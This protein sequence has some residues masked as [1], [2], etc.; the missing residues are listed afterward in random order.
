[1]P[2]FH[3]AVHFEKQDF[4][5]NNIRLFEIHGGRGYAGINNGSRH[6]GCVQKNVIY[7][8]NAT[9]TV[10]EINNRDIDCKLYERY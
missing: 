6:G 2:T 8:I 10:H 3:H 1:M 5:R 9:K 4:A 7:A